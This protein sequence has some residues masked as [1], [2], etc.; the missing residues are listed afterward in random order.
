MHAERARVLAPARGDILELGVGT[1]LNFPHYPR[2]VERIT[3]LA[4]DP[5][6]DRLARERAA[7]RGL[8]VDYVSG[9]AR[10]LPF[11]AA[12]FDTV[13]ATLVLC[14]IPEP[15]RAIGEARRVLR[16]GGSL[17]VFEHV[18]RPKGWARGFQYAFEPANR[19][20]GCGCSLLC[21]TRALLAAAD[22]SELVLE[23]RI[24][25]ALSFQVAWVIS[26]YA[27]K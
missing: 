1:G 13:V 11:D 25:P 23:E 22:F 21:D 18:I 15:A 4:P 9:D 12:R 17:L 2:A 27:R 14:T 6:M 20:F 19:L 5:A 7:A 16:S 8:S 3:A 26:G 10:A 24:S